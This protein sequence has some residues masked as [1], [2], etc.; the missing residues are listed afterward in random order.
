M[1]IP[2][3]KSS[4]PA[5]DPIAQDCNND[6]IRRYASASDLDSNSNS[7]SNSVCGVSELAGIRARVL[8]Y[9]R[10]TTAYAATPSPVTV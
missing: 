7:D 3:Q 5:T 6:L 9:Y 8:M 4:L 10:T 2:K 1:I